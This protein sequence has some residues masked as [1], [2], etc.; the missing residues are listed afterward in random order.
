LDTFFKKPIINL[1]MLLSDS[2]V[3]NR[4]TATQILN[5]LANKEYIKVLRKGA[6]SS[7][8]IFAFPSLIDIVENR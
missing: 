4:K 6:G 7:P 8:T 2:G 3:S 1:T 5:K